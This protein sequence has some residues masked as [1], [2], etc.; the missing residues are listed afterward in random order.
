MGGFLWVSK[1]GVLTFED[2]GTRLGVSADHTWGDN[3][4]STDIYPS[5]IDYDLN[6][7]D[8]VSQVTVEPNIFKAAYRAR[9]YSEWDAGRTRPAAPIH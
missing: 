6:D 3:S 2:R 4:A 8:L 1:T 5:R 9:R 7:D